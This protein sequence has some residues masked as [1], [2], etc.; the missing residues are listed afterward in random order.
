MGVLDYVKDRI[1]NRGALTKTPRD[2][3]DELKSGYDYNSPDL[4]DFPP[5]T[6][7][8][9]GPDLADYAVPSVSEV[10]QMEPSEFTAK[11]SPEAKKSK[12]LKDISEKN[13][14]D[15]F[16]H[17]KKAIDAT[18]ESSDKGTL[19]SKTGKEEDYMSLK[20]PSQESPYE[21]TF[22]PSSKPSQTDAW[23]MGS[24]K[25]EVETPKAEIPKTEVPP[26]V[27]PKAP[28]A[29]VE[30][31]INTG[32][33]KEQ[34]GS[35]ESI[36]VAEEKKKKSTWDI[37]KE[38]ISG[39][40]GSVNEMEYA[41][42]GGYTDGLSKAEIL[43]EIEALKKKNEVILGRIKE[44]DSE[45][46]QAKKDKRDAQE[47]LKQFSIGSKERTDLN[48]E[49][50]RLENEIIRL[51]NRRT[52]LVSSYDENIISIKKY[53]MLIL[54]YD[55][56]VEIGRS[57]P[58]AQR[59]A[60]GAKLQNIA[61][62]SQDVQFM[63]KSARLAKSDW[64]GEKGFLK[65]PFKQKNITSSAVEPVKVATRNLDA[66]TKST[67]GSVARSMIDVTKVSPNK[68]IAPLG[69]PGTVGGAK[70]RFEYSIP[71]K[72]ITPADVTTNINRDIMPSIF[73][74][75]RQMQAP[76]QLQQVVQA[77][78]TLAEV[79][80]QQRKAKLFTVS[81]NR[82]NAKTS[83]GNGIRRFDTG[84][85]VT[86]VDRFKPFKA[87]SIGSKGDMYCGTKKVGKID[88]CTKMVR[89]NIGLSDIGQSRSLKTVSI[90]KRPHIDLG[91]R[92]PKNTGFTIDGAGSSN[93][94]DTVQS[95]DRKSK[96]SSPKV[97]MKAAL[98]ISGNINKFLLK[99]KTK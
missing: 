55:Q 39:T 19:L 78:G 91:L 68:N 43:A 84:N 14:E 25:P 96:M 36:S 64:F 47:Q 97:N 12:V 89:L 65:Q 50:K 4:G 21:K 54:K 33:E 59:K 41:R 62:G 17:D 16:K 11:L 49:I 31:V 13:F 38:N 86:G 67:G 15:V 93:I 70:Q 48:A 42:R 10:A 56:Y 37:F 52:I 60:I 7:E 27:T 26:T 51:E 75:P 3:G 72:K 79:P 5:H 53:R 35:K 61:A 71:A 83:K 34:T 2:S 98:K 8:D 30:P 57:K 28:T 73:S 90:G 32:G 44:L 99:K 94:I 69:V 18:L 81:V 82:Y 1:G 95:E 23:W 58:S 76:V 40:D 92:S 88:T 24:D 22:E 63:D 45:W 9:T 66:V 74:P 80:I 20:I 29:T 85:I 77:D 46:N 6:N 87:T